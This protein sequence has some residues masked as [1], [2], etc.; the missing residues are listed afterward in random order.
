MTSPISAGQTMVT[1]LTSDGTTPVAQQRIFDLEI[2][3]DS[4]A[5]YTQLMSVIQYALL[6][7]KAWSPS[8]GIGGG[9]DEAGVV[10]TVKAAVAALNLWSQ[11]KHVNPDGTQ[12]NETWVP[13]GYFFVDSTGH[14]LDAGTTA[15]TMSRYMAQGLDSLIRTLSAAGFNPL[16]SGSPA[17]GVIQAIQDDDTSSSPVYNLRSVLGIALAA[18]AKAIIAGDSSTSSQ[19]IQQLLMIDYISSGNEILYGQMNLLQSAVTLNQNILSFLNSLQDLMN[20][21]DPKHFL[22]QLQNLNSASPDYSQFEKETFGDQILGTIPKFTGEE[23]DTYISNLTTSQVETGGDTTGVAGGAFGPTPVIDP[24]SPASKAQQYLDRLRNN[25]GALI[26]NGSEVAD[27]TSLITQLK[28]IQADFA[29]VSSIDDWVT[30]FAANN[31][32]TYQAHLNDAVVASQ[33]LND[34]QREKLQ[35]VMFVYQSFYQSATSMLNAIQTLM[36]SLASN[37][38]SQ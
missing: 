34:T 15:S 20:Q 17:T 8:G 12:H 6:D 25:I 10:S 24:N 19:S 33:A 4:Q 30:N 38:S 5:Y 28:I 37:I 35:Q 18:A 21:K 3:R 23:I 27:G 22:M 36:Q 7:H 13:N 9:L 1:F 31:E 16:A 2:T 14:Q 11:D 29:A 26:T 32:G